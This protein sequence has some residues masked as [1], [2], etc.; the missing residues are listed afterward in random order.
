MAFRD[1]PLQDLRLPLAWAAAVAT[2]VAL[3]VALILLLGHRRA[4][5]AMSAYAPARSTFDRTAAPVG[6]TLEAPV[7]WTGDAVAYMRGYFFAISE[8]RRLKQQIRELEGWRDTAIA[9]RNVNDRYEALL[10]LKTEP[11]IPMVAARTVLDARGPFADARLLDVGAEAGVQVGDP[12]MSEHGV[13]GRIVGAA[14]GVSRLLMLTDVESRT[15]VLVDRTNARAILTGDG[16]GYPKLE[17]VRGRDPVK[18][19]DLILTSGDGGV[20][21]RGL[22]VGV[23]AR[24]LSQAWRVRLYSDQTPIDFVRILLFQDFGSAVDPASLPGGNAPP[25]TAAEQADRA[26]T[27][28]RATQP[29]SPSPSPPSGAQANPQASAS[30]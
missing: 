23:A 7:R 15:P 17:Y 5:V 28:Q 20:F 29:P 11:E 16:G 24:D 1:G 2:A 18:D 10:K 13:V 14:R 30:R 26:A 22:P 19:G 21:P 8:N 3:I 12:V 27:L 4:P 9:L 6:E 25:L